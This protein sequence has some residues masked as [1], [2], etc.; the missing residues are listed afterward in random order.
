LK[1]GEKERDWNLQC[2]EMRVVLL[3]QL[4]IG[5]NW[6]WLAVIIE[7]IRGLKPRGGTQ[8]VISKPPN[9]FCK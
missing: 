1:D 4:R 3:I 9:T 8:W 6:V 2:A 5:E 7:Q